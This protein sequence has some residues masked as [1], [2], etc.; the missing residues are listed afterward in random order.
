MSHIDINPPPFNL[1]KATSLD[2]LAGMHVPSALPPPPSLCCFSFVC[3]LTACCCAR[4]NSPCLQS[5][6]QYF[7]GHHNPRPT[8]AFSSPWIPW[9]LFFQASWPFNPFPFKVEILV[10]GH[11]CWP[12]AFSTNY[13]QP[14][15][16]HSHFTV[17]N[18]QKGHVPS[19]TQSTHNLPR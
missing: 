7:C 17:H 6:H 11:Y 8:L 13:S 5:L 18:H 15:V 4:S 2:T 14:R 10:I 12:E 3:S 9:P 16:L 19:E 1:I